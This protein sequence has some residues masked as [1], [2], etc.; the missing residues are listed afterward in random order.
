MRHYLQRLATSKGKG[1]SPP[2]FNS[3]TDTRIHK[4]MRIKNLLNEHKSIAKE[5]KAEAKNYNYLSEAVR[6]SSSKEAFREYQAS[7]RKL[8]SLNN[9]AYRIMVEY[10]ALCGTLKYKAMFLLGILPKQHSFRYMEGSRVFFKYKQL[11]SLLSLQ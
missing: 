4:D 3:T 8:I 7:W 6:N 1:E 5:M 9:R 2:S 11:L 10:R